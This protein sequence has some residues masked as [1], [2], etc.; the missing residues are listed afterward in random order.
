MSVDMGVGW[1][2]RIMGTAMLC[3]STVT[4]LYIRFFTISHRTL[5]E[6]E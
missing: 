2:E 5:M 1:K 3:E 6:I 4:L